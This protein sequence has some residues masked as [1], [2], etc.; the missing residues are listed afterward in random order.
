MIYLL[1]KSWMMIESGVNSTILPS[2]PFVIWYMERILF[3]KW[4]THKASWKFLSP[5]LRDPFPITLMYVLFPINIGGIVHGWNEEKI[6]CEDGI[7]WDAPESRSHHLD[8][9]L[10]VA[11]R[12]YPLF[13]DVE[14]KPTQPLSLLEYF[15]EG[16]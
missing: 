10:E 9:G 15:E 1:S 14:A 12:D 8:L 16:E 6:V 7:W 2:P 5:K 13:P 11:Q 3:V 4:G